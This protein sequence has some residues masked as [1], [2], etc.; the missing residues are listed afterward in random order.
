MSSDLAIYLSKQLY[1]TAF[2]VSSPV[3]LVALFSGLLISILQVITQI[4][5]STLSV[6][7][8]MLAAVLMLMFAG[9]WMLHQ[10]M[11]FSTSIIKRI[12]ESIL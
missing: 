12:P 3:V 11:T 2:L 8:K 5:D 4:Q 7:P 1:W 10:L 6:V 9:S